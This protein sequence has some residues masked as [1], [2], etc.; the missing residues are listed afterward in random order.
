M[1]EVRTYSGIQ[2]EKL[3]QLIEDLTSE[4]GEVSSKIEQMSDGSLKVQVKPK[5][6]GTSQFKYS[7]SGKA[8]NKYKK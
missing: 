2:P 7:K 8:G 5:A 4:L 6:S 1:S 3:S